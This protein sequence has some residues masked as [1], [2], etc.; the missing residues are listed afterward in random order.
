MAL[1]GVM[2]MK[3]QKPG[4]FNFIAT[5]KWDYGTEIVSN[6]ADRY[7]EGKPQLSYLLEAPNAVKGECLVWAYGAKKYARRNWQKGLP[8][9]S[10]LDSLMRHAT[11]FANGEDLDP[12]SGLP[13]V[14][15]MQCNTRILAE[16]FRTHPELDDRVKAEGKS[17]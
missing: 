10:V 15:M 4:Q 8:W 9:M 7:N 5:I 1:N 17:A 14:D 3:Y 13:H 12:E 6:I 11:A 2:Q 16:Y